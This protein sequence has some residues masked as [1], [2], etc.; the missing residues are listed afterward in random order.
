MEIRPH[1]IDVMWGDARADAD[2]MAGSES[3]WGAC[4]AASAGWGGLV[5]ALGSWVSFWLGVIFC[6]V[7]VGRSCLLSW[8]QSLTSVVPRDSASGTE[9][10]HDMHPEFRASELPNDLGTRHITQNQLPTKQE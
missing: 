1:E 2:G 7:V 3:S 6:V 9:L 5:A 8:F 10:S 4:D